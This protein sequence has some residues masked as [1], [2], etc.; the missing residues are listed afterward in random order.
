MTFFHISSG[1]GGYYGGGGGAHFS[2]GGGGSGY[3]SPTCIGGVSTSS[4]IPSPTPGIVVGGGYEAQGGSGLALITY[5]CAAGK[6]TCITRKSS[7][8]IRHMGARS[9][10]EHECF[11]YYSNPGQTA[12]LFETIPL[13]G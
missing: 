3:L 8:A 7:M 1:G 12:I 9:T 2:G 6:G 13:N 5:T 4:Y 11:H 10:S